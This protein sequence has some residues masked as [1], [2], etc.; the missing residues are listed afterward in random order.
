MNKIRVID[1]PSYVP[2]IRKGQNY[3]AGWRPSWVKV[4]TSLLGN[5]AFAALSLADVG[6]YLRLVL[7]SA[8]AQ[9]G[10]SDWPL[11]PAEAGL[12]GRRLGMPLRNLGRQLERLSDAGLIEVADATPAVPSGVDERGEDEKGLDW[13]GLAPTGADEAGGDESGFD[14]DEAFDAF[15]AEL[16]DSE[17]HRPSM[18][19]TP[20]CF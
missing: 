6:L 1:W 15:V 4:A 18:T 10:T 16:A 8:E 14:P 19:P 9:R 20:S 13:I 5:D 12:L 2:A 3:S 7:A 17:A 11:L